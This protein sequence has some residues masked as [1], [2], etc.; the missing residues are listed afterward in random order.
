MLRR[1]LLMAAGVLGVFAAGVALGLLLPR[2]AARATS[3]VRPGN[4]GNGEAVPR[5]ED[6]RYPGAVSRA[7]EGSPGFEDNGRL[8]VTPLHLQLWATPD[9]CDKVTA[10]YATKCGFDLKGGG[11]G[12]GSRMRGAD[13]WAYLGVND[14]EAGPLR[15][16]YL[17]RRC[18]SYDLTVVITRVRDEGRTRIALVYEPKVV[19]SVP[20][21]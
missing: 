12:G 11:D 21:K 13:L 2:G 14:K 10:F 5:L 17:R 1:R 3:D 15:E 18:G 9:D 8:V 4:A 20:P 6:W 7:Y 16:Q 19:E